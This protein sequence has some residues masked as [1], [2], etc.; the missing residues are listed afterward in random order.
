[1][2]ARTAA[3]SARFATDTNEWGLSV[4]RG[5]GGNEEGLDED[6]GAAAVAWYGLAPRLELP[7]AER[8]RVDAPLAKRSRKGVGDLPEVVDNT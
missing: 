2:T 8:N 3:S 4:A 7:I 6:L 1:M 5:I